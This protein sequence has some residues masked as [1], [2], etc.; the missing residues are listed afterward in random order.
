MPDQH[1]G[2]LPDWGFG[3]ADARAIYLTDLHKCQPASALTRDRERRRWRMLDYE[4][5]GFNGTM[6]TASL[7]TDAPDVTYPLNLSGWHAISIGVHRYEREP[8]Q[9]LRLRLSG[10][11]VFSVL[12][13]AAG[14]SWGNRR[15]D[16]LFWKVA[17]LSGEQIVFGQATTRTGPGDHPSA[18]QCQK[19]R[20]SYIKLV[21]LTDAEARALQ[22]DRA[23]TDTRRLFAHNDAH[24]P[25]YLYRPTTAEEIRREIEP[26][27]DSDFAR[28]YWE[29]GTGD[30]AYFLSEVGRV[31]TFENIG[32]FE[33]P[34]DRLHAES[35]RAF[36]AQ[37]VD[38]F[39]VALDYAHEL[40]L[41]FHACYRPGSFLNRPPSN[42]H[43][44]L[45]GWGERHPELRT[46]GRDGRVGPRTSFAY[47]ETRE[48][49]ARLV[50]DA[51]RRPIDG[52][53]VLYNRRGGLLE[54]E[55]PIVEGFQREFGEDS[56]ELSPHDQRWLTYRAT[57]LTPFMRA[58]RAGLDRVAK[59][60]GR[61]RIE[62]SAVVMSTPEES[63]YY[64]LDL[65]AWIREGLVDLLIP[66]SSAPELE[67]ESEAWTAPQTVAPWLALTRG[68]DCG[69]ALNVMPR[70]M[71][72]ARLRRRA[73][74][75]Y[76]QGIENLFFWDCAGPGGRANGGAQWNALRRLGHVD[77]IRAWV[78]T[79]EPEPAL[80]GARLLSLKSWDMTR[81]R[82]G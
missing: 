76:E 21:P 35:W 49:A 34:G 62:L 26:Y 79:G 80:P 78:E 4:S 17:D 18:V 9:T 27:R 38:P 32:D 61:K 1:D 37:G 43:A 41:E 59:E 51:A 75:L 20:V 2:R 13:L 72:P 52:V 6:I 23:R 74:E 28:I 40:G 48:F 65:S 15:H 45:G 36:R 63:L 66:Y 44:T 10:D 8:V 50:L 71:P 57:F 53:C 3:A 60:E 55:P 19:A 31:P 69:L 58:L 39:E 24:G 5:D 30:E 46:V 68:T 64:G 81:I 70:F 33:R 16:E 11:K 54:Y 47:S 12:T 67:S 22:A 29:C 25:H 42:D 56:R 73:F 82:P 7:E 14:G 77:E